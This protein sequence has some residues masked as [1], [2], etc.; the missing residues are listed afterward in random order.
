MT[1][2]FIRAVLKINVRDLLSRMKHRLLTWGKGGTIEL[3]IVSDKLS[4][5]LSELEV[6]MLI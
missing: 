6:V 4:D 1:S 5:F 2:D 3:S